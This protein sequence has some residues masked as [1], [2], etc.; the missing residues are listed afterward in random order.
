MTVLICILLSHALSVLPT[1]QLPAPASDYYLDSNV[2]YLNTGTLGP[3]PRFVVENATRDWQ[4]LETMPAN[5]Y[6]GAF[7]PDPFTKR[8]EIV[9]QKAAE[10]LGCLKTELSLT[11]STT[12]SLNNVAAGLVS[13][14]FLKSGDHVL[15]TDQE[16]AGG[17]VCWSHYARCTPNLTSHGWPCSKPNRSTSDLITLDIMPIPVT[18]VSA[19]PTTVAEIVALF[20]AALDKEPNT[21]VVAVSHVTTTHGLALPMPEIAALVHSRGALLIVDG[22][23]AMGLDV[24]LAEMGVGNASWSTAISFSNRTDF[25]LLCSR[26]VD[27]Y[28]TSAHKWML[29]PKG[30]GLLYIAKTAQQHITPIILDGGSGVYTAQTGTRPAHT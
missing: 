28:A 10:Y 8:Q 12:I 17:Y 2:T 21:R 14:G 9:H 1:R 23:Q 19:A 29:A 4:I 18:P 11:P 16:H 3:C 15:T 25:A 20:R 5:E 26:Q 13:S 30:S 27:A 24:N 6:F 7:T 22:A